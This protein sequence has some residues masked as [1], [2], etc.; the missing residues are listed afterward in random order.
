LRRLVNIQFHSHIVTENILDWDG[1]D[2][3]HQW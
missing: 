2:K 1:K 3:V